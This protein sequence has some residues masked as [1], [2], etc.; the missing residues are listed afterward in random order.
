M[1]SLPLKVSLFICRKA[2]PVENVTERRQR[3][4]K[5]KKFNSFDLA[6]LV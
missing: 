3:Q 2:A 6:H 1:A 4:Q 5:K